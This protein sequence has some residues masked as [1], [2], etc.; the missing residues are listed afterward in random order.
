MLAEQK[1]TVELAKGATRVSMK[2]A[3][4]C[5]GQSAPIRHDRSGEPTREGYL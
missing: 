1:A 3:K 4:I 5:P 2:N